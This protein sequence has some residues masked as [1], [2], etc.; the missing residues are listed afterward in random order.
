MMVIQV[1][2]IL[3]AVFAL[4]RAVSRY[5]EGRLPRPW[6]A[7]WVLFWFVVVFVTLSPK[8][9]DKIAHIVGVGRGADFVLYVSVAALFYLVFRLFVKIEDVERDVTRLS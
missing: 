3:F 6:L 5:R 1:L 7:F 9:A 2:I 8:V 4:A